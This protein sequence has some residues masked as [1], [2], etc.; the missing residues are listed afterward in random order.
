MPHPF[1][2]DQL[3]AK[4]INALNES[5]EGD[6]MVFVAFADRQARGLA[7]Q[8]AWI[9]EATLNGEL[10]AEDREWFLENLKELSTNFART[11]VA[12]TLLTIE[13]AW[14]AIVGTL[15]EAINGTISAAIGIVLPVPAP[16]GT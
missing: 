8:A 1:D 7:K 13:K 5:L 10:T 4:I 9:A 14:N 3:G 2:V 15:W 16:P 11:V 6:I 12:L